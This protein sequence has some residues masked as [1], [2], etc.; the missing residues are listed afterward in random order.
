MDIFSFT[1]GRWRNFGLPFVDQQLQQIRVY[2]ATELSDCVSR[3]NGVCDCYISS[4]EYGPD[5]KSVV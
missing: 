2:N 4:C 5:R 3:W 1:P